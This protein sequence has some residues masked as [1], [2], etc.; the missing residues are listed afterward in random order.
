[1]FD[2]SLLPKMVKL[3]WECWSSCKALLRR[4]SE[5]TIRTETFQAAGPSTRRALKRGNPNEEAF[6]GGRSCSWNHSSTHDRG[7]DLVGRL[8]GHWMLGPVRHR[9]PN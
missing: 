5:P 7:D 1:M 3:Q 2:R 9:G 4:P 6:L 8:D